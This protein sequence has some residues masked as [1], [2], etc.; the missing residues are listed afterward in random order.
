MSVTFTKTAAVSFGMLAAHKKP[1][2]FMTY[3][4]SDQSNPSDETTLEDVTVGT[5]KRLLDLAY[6][7]YNTAMKDGAH[8]VSSYWDGYIRGIQHVLEARHE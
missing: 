2:V 1:P 5:C 6:R 3:E 8:A 7:N 4:M